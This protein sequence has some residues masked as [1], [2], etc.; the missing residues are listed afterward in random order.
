MCGVCGCSEGSS[1]TITHP[2][3]SHSHVNADGTITTHAHHGEAGHTHSHD[4]EHAHAHE[5]HD[6][7]HAH[8]HEGH[9][10]AHVHAHGHAHSHAQSST[11]VTVEAIETEI[12]AKNDRLAERNRG[13]LAG[14]EVF[15]VNLMSSPGSGKTTLLERTLKGLDTPAAVL[16]GDQETPLDAERIRATGAPV[17]QINTGKGCHLEAEMVWHGLETLRPALGSVLFIE[18]V[19]NLVCPALFDLG[20]AKRVVL[21]STTEGEDKP[22]KYPH[23][24][25]AA[26]LVILSKT[27]LIPHLDFDHARAIGSVKEINP[28]AE[29][30]E[31]SARTGEGM[32]AWFTWLKSQGQS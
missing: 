16:E 31:L 22:L 3:G 18:N 29:I 20:E 1:T 2:D 12:F 13:W 23:M 21:F 17:A 25:K 6:H 4:H 26:D 32:D 7:V 24:F 19:G 27:D 15:A 30:L 10:H 28:D 8:A 11:K 14:R 9:G 5:G